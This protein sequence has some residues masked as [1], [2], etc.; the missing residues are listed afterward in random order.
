MPVTT[1]PLAGAYD[2]RPYTNADSTKDQQFINALFEVIGDPQLE[3]KEI[4][5]F[6]RPGVPSST[7]SG[8][9]RAI[10]FSPSVS[11]SSATFLFTGASNGVITASIT[12][13]ATIG[14]ISGTP[15]HFSEVLFSS[16]T[17]ILLTSSD[18]TGWF[19]ASDSFTNSSGTPT[20]ATFTGNRTSGSPI[21]TSVSSTAGLYVGQ[22]V[23]GTGIPASTR[24]LSIDSSS[25]IT[26]TANATSG[27][28]TSTTFTREAIAKIIDSNFPTNITGQF[29]ELNGTVYIMTTDS[30]V[31]GSN[32][33]T[34]ITWSAQNYFT[35]N[36]LTDSGIGLGKIKDVILGIGT[37][38]VEILKDAGNADG[39]PLSRI[40]SI[41]G[42]GASLGS[43]GK[44]LICSFYDRVY[45]SG[46][47]GNCYVY[48]GQDARLIGGIGMAGT[49][50]SAATNTYESVDGFTSSG[51]KYVHF[52]ALSTSAG[53]GRVYSIDSDQWTTSGYNSLYISDGV[54][55]RSYYGTQLFYVTGSISGSPVT[56]SV[57]SSAAAVFIDNNIA[58]Y[59]LTIQTKPFFFNKG[60]PFIIDNITLLADTQSGGTTTL[61]TSADDYANFGTV[62]TFDL[63]Q[64]QKNL[65]GGGYYDTSVA[66]KLTDS[67]NN[68]WRGQALQITWRPSA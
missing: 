65:A 19:I 3:S 23:T 66:F 2:R 33:N 16:I 54:G 34:V 37:Q 44:A 32:I 6:K 38:S 60:L 59:T 45:W 53:G 58:S 11:T 22:S 43:R 4:Y 10:W 51:N 15:L 68:A 47:G 46:Y 14:T 13:S 26:L 29:V 40:G 8:G 39:S 41:V 36:V 17:Y 62:G 21:I 24:I 7:F 9:G 42:R 50:Q 57:D 25:Q 12:F 35:C 5:I 56:S 55:S 31:Y 49:L 63:T 67:G 1:I 27:S 61:A 28:G 20:I 48:D 64:Q 52:M 18:G 30:R